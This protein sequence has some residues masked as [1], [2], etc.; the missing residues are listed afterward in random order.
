MREYL[1]NDHV[2]DHETFVARALDPAANCVVEACAGSGKTWLL[3][4]RI[5]RLLLAGVAPGRILAITFTRRAAQEMNKRLIDDLAALARGSDDEVIALLRPRGMSDGEARAAVPL[6]RS[7]YELVACAQVPIVMDTFHGWFLRLV[8]AAPLHLSPGYAPALLENVNELL[9]ESWE[10]FCASLLREQHAGLR[11]AYEELTALA[12]DDGAE[13]LLRHFVARRIDWW[14]FAQAGADPIDRAIE[15]MRERMLLL[16]A[17]ADAH[18]GVLVRSAPVRAHLRSMVRALDAVEKPGKTHVGTVDALQLW[19]ADEDAADASG[20]A[21]NA[22]SLRRLCTILLTKPGTPLAVLH[23]ESIAKKLGA[24]PELAQLYEQAHAAVQEGLDRARDA[25]REWDALRLTRCGL[26]CGVHLLGIF[27]ERKQAASA[28]DF[29]DLEW[30][31]HRLLSDPDVASYMQT[32]LD[33]RV[34]HLLVDEFQD[35]NPMQWQALQSW[36]HSYA[37]A[38]ERPGVFLVGDP[39]QSI[40]RF[41]GAEPR[42]FDVARAQLQRDFGAF[43]LRTNVT[44]RNPPELVEVFNRV[45]VGGNLLFEAQS[46]RVA[47]GESGAE[48]L[49]LPLIPSQP[50]DDGDDRGAGVGGDVRDPL[51]T[52]RPESLRDRHYQEALRIADLLRDRLQH[53]RVADKRVTR[54]VGGDGTRPADWSDVVIL[55]RKRTHLAEMERAFRDRRVPHVSSRRGSLLVQLEIEDLC[56]LL[57]FLC[58]P[59]DDLAL[60]RSLRS[61]LF[62]CEESDLITLARTGRS[63]WSSLLALEMPGA[64]LER[65]RGLLAGFLPKVDILPVHDL[66]DH[67]L[68]A[69]EARLRYAQAVPAASCAQ[70]QANIDAFLELALDLDSGR[71]PSLTRF[72]S[73]LRDLQERDDSDAN[74]GIAAGENAVRILTI[75]AAK[76]LEAPV[77]VLPGTN[78]FPSQD[79]RNDVFVAWAPEEAAPE[80]FSLVGNAKEIGAARAHWVEADR[81]QREQED[82]N[83]L[84]V[85]M[86]RAQRLLIVSGVEMPNAGPDTWYARIAACV[87][88][89]TE[90]FEAGRVD[91]ERQ[92]GSTLRLYRDF[93]PEPRPAGAR[94]AEFSSDAMRLGRAWHAVLQAAGEPWHAPWTP[95][96]LAQAFAIAPEAAQ[97]ALAAAER[98]RAAPHLRKF[99]EGPVRADDELDLIGNDGEVLRLDRLV[100]VGGECWVLD[101]KWQ[102]DEQTLPQYERQVRRYAVCL[103]DTGESRP[104]RGLLIAADA[105][106]HEV[107]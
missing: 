31:A 85:A 50:D 24:R 14:C 30:H 96:D 43:S 75:H 76:G 86:T 106:T 47:S 64:S 19:L 4:G 17:A 104:I 1:V 66:L 62:A 6:A 52:P 51:S 63:W 42:I 37:G 18:P 89:N 28:L 92:R 2:A 15:P 40:Y 91:S 3:V 103:R 13:T 35:T 58:N 67:V 60:A 11:A 20:L 94:R 56:A 69:C 72:L 93:R 71:F 26:A 9:D 77:V 39:K 45:F 7:L 54:A 80:H 32:W 102:W 79:D 84:Y 8:R 44:W 65:A 74:E 12:G 46:T 87:P 97:R 38:G 59:G 68:F 53:I 23:P 99:F 22:R 107:N 21:D 105:S 83:L 27:Q 90:T 78:P 88:V 95:G 82:W 36:L 98:V 61:P 57:S 29:A 101:Y 25:L 33:A 5:L 70:A 10:E 100:E 49:L 41:R 81:T 16:G 48:F 55:V 34:R 73:E